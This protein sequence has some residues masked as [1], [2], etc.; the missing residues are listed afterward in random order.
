MQVFAKLN[1]VGR[2]SFALVFVLAM[3]IALGCSSSATTQG[4]YA[5]SDETLERD[6]A[7]ALVADYLYESEREEHL[8]RVAVGERSRSPSRPS[9]NKWTAEPWGS[10]GWKVSTTGDGVWLVEGDSRNPTY[11]KS[12]PTATPT[13]SSSS[14]SRA[15][16]S[17]YIPLIVAPRP[18]STPI[19][20]P[21]PTPTPYPAN[22]FPLGDRYDDPP[23]IVIM[24]GTIVTWI[25]NS[26]SPQSI[27]SCAEKYCLEFSGAWASGEILPGKSYSLTFNQT[28]TFYYRKNES[29]SRTS[30]I[31]VTAHTGTQSAQVGNQSTAASSSPQGADKGCPSGF[32]EHLHPQGKWSI[33]LPTT[34]TIDPVPGEEAWDMYGAT[35]LF[36]DGRGVAVS[37]LA[38]YGPE[39]LEAVTDF[40][41]QVTEDKS[42]EL[43]V[44]SYDSY[45]WYGY[46]AYILELTTTNAIGQPMR[47]FLMT[48]AA[49]GNVYSLEVFCPSNIWSLHESTM[50]TIVE[51]FLIA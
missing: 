49:K 50:V 19:P 1:P 6:R 41:V 20:T 38:N 42:F 29:V 25:N 23:Q 27:D 5:Y 24:Q 17:P 8:A 40:L 18:T 11:L 31:H 33:C 51:Y 22:T 32:P 36:K 47:R 12:S 21:I 3:T 2:F 34:W 30:F 48:V 39:D 15:T 4:Q 13:R 46:D 45:D 7:I 26:Q 35:P 37:E 10:S 43:E 16:P 28:G 9:A 14:V 44:I